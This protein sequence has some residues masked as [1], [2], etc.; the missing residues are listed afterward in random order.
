MT[1]ADRCRK[2]ISWLEAL[3]LDNP[4]RLGILLGLADWYTELWLLEGDA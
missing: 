4:D 1:A 2:E 3:P